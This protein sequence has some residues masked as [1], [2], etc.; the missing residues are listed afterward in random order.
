MYTFPA[1]RDV[2]VGRS[3]ESDIRLDGVDKRGWISPTHLVLRFDGTRWLAIDQSRTGIYLQGVRTSTL[4]IRD[5]QIITVGDPREG[6]QLRF[7]IAV[8]TRQDPVG[9]A[10]GA[11]PARTGV[12]TIGRR[13]DC[14][15]VV[16]DPLVSRVHAK[17]LP[18]PA[19][20]EIADNISINGTFVNGRRITR[21]LVR[22]GDIVTLGNTD[23]TVSG[24]TL[25][26]WPATRRTGGVEAHRLGL[27]I[28]GH[29]LLSDVSFTARP[30]T[31]TA[32][33][34][35]S[36]AGKTTL[37]KLLGGAMQ[38]SLGRVSF[39]GHDVHAEYASMRSRIGV[40][41]Q[42]DVVHRKLTV[43]QALG[44]AAELRLPPDT[45]AADCRQVVAEVIDELE[46]TPH[47]KTRVDKLS[48]GQ[49]K[50]AS[51]AME[52]LTGP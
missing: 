13:E 45:S 25:V 38:P 26:P 1:G 5:G 17:L 47:R 7:R 52:L 30:G 18:T 48:G 31:L 33:I 39:D 46:L 51:V 10:T 9:R 50:R 19:G 29:P 3:S 24:A 20:P 28:A 34:G 35:P 22:D 32:V 49:R 40:V 2:T 11:G 6:P 15:M 4:A 41:P 42:D 16:R 21:T 43:E 44:Y 14:D 8:A 36:G 23:F 12:L 27:S 37:I